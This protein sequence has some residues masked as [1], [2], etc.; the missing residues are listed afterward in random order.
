[1]T[2]TAILPFLHRG[3]K[4]L[5]RVPRPHARPIEI[6]APDRRSTDLLLGYAAQLCPAEIAP[7][8]VWIVRVELP[9]GPGWMLKLLS[10]VQDWLESA[11]LPW[12]TVL[13]EGQSYLIRPSTEFAEF[14]AATGS[15]LEG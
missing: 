11:R 8:S 15:A 13:Y 6:F 2:D 1:M 5:R 4:R 7:G 10:L 9:A 14:A 12:A 3:R